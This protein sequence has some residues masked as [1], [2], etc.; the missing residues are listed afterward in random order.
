MPPP[1]P[2]RAAAPGEPE[3]DEQ[4]VDKLIAPQDTG[5][6]SRRRDRRLCAAVDDAGWACSRWATLDSD[7]CAFHQEAPS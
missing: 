4:I 1:D 6:V 7:L 3:G 5:G 2:E